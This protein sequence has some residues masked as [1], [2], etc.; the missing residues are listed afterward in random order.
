MVE[1]KLRFVMAYNNSFYAPVLNTDLG[2]PTP[3]VYS[4]I[5]ILLSGQ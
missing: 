4:W 3:I 2:Q 1:P 5:D